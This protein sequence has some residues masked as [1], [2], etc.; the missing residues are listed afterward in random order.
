MHTAW[1]LNGTTFDSLIGQSYRTF[2]DNLFAENTGL[3]NQ[4]SDVVAR[5][6]FAPTG[7][8][9]LTYRTRLDQATLAT[10][11]ID[12]VGTVGSGAFSVNAG[13]LYTA[14]NPYE[15]YDQPLPPPTST[16]FFTPRREVTAGLTARWGEYRLTATAQ[17]DLQ[18]SQ[19][20]GYGVNAAYEN[21][22]FIVALLVNRRVTSYNGDNGSTSAII[23]VTFKTVGT[24]GFSAL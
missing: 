9:S 3:H 21:E 5:A 24:F 10:R 7:W 8:L 18:T 14:D 17:R 15:E 20:D 6:S 2:K 19:M 13:Y 11:M 12:A 22:C 1:Y 23:Q 4:V 16:T